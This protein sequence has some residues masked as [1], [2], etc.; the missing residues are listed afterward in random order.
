MFR[1]FDMNNDGRVDLNELKKGYERIDKKINEDELE[2]IF[3]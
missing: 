1:D 2:K 3:A